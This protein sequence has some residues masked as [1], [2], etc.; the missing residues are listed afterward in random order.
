[1]K[2]ISN[3]ILIQHPSTV[4]KNRSGYDWLIKKDADK[5]V[6][7]DLRIK[8]DLVNT[9]DCLYV[10]HFHK[11]YKG[12]RFIGGCDDAMEDNEAY[13]NMVSDS[14]IAGFQLTQMG[15]DRNGNIV[16]KKSKLKSRN[17]KNLI[18]R[19]IKL[20]YHIR[21][22]H[23]DC[24]G[25]FVEI[26]EFDGCMSQGET[27]DKAVSNIHKAMEG[28][29]EYMLESGVAV[30]DPIEVTDERKHRK[31]WKGILRKKKEVK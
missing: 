20:P 17:R 3:Y 19:Y 15:M 9:S 18:K 1:M 22:I 7:N 27:P 10:L 28:W 29:L 4:T 8:Q 24:G 16:I 21:L 12:Y 6:F 26:E 31:K 2:R 23:D 14:I 13:L 5:T 30:P 11:L 25:Y